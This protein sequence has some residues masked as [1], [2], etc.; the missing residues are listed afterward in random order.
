MLD[1]FNCIAL[2]GFCP[3]FFKNC[4][5]SLCQAATQSLQMQ[6]LPLASSGTRARSSPGITAS[7]HQQPSSAL[8][9]AIMHPLGLLQMG[10]TPG[11]KIHIFL[12]SMTLPPSSMGAMSMVP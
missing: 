1:H 9:A 5:R 10:Q 4:P 12:V 7:V 3:I 8:P 2:P 6:A 11:S